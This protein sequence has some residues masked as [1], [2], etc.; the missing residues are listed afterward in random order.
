MNPSERC[1][2]HELRK[3]IQRK[4]GIKRQE[5]ILSL[6][7]EMK[8]ILSTAKLSSLRISKRRHLEDP[9]LMTSN[10]STEA[11]RDSYFGT[12]YDIFS[13]LLATPILCR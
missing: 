11:R 5:R 9:A 3:A 4:A 1:A 12:V 2:W 6:V 8:G 10:R 13:V 7:K